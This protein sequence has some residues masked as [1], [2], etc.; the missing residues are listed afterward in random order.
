MHDVQKIVSMSV[1]MDEPGGQRMP[2]KKKLGMKDE[3]KPSVI[4]NKL[5]FKEDVWNAKRIPNHLEQENELSV[6]K[7][8]Q[9]RENK[10]KLGPQQI[11][12]K[13]WK[14]S[15]CVLLVAKP[16]NVAFPILSRMST[17]SLCSSIL[18]MPVLLV[19]DKKG[20][21]TRLQTTIGFL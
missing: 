14:V 20:L 16:A 12:K 4:R 3:R 17:K 5:A 1:N 10:E 13:S 15:G 18:A 8:P 21:R 19:V 2:S 11:V 9:K 6:P 7:I